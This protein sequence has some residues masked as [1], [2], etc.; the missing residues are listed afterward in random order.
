MEEVSL[1]VEGTRVYGEYHP[2]EGR[3]VGAVVLLHGFASCVR[4]FG[5]LPRRLAGA[6][7]A[8]LAIDLRG[9]GLSAGERGRLGL[10]RAI[11][12]VQ[13]GVEMLR[14]RHPR[15]RIGFVG[16]SLGGALGLGIASR[17]DLFDAMVV[18][19]PV[20]RLFDELPLWEKA[21]YHALGRLAN[22]RMSQGKRAGS[23]RRRPRYRDLFVDTE[24]GRVAKRQ[25]FLDDRVNL[26]NYAFATTMQASDWARRVRLPVLCV[27][28][29]H[30]RTVDPAHAKAVCQALSGPTEVLI[31]D[32]GHS[33]FLDRDA[34]TVQAGVE[35]FLVRTLGGR[36]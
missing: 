1:T 35:G 34:E 14:E 28:S 15:A 7:L 27:Q 19:H 36:A 29:P 25:R 21:A 33:C 32:G 30:D 9:H 31:H 11:Q 22:R 6:G 2:P 8:S 3:P 26:A 10:D 20:D 17:T 18:A 16:H 12:D 4:D 5:L 13:A 23:V 24:L